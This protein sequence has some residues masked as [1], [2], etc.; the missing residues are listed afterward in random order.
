MRRV[1]VPGTLRDE[2][3]LKGVASRT[4]TPVRSG[5]RAPRCT[6]P[7]AAT[8]GHL[9][10]RSGSWPSSRPGCVGPGRPY[11]ELRLDAISRSAAI[12]CSGPGTNQDQDQDEDQ[13]RRGFDRPGRPESSAD[14]RT[15][16]HR[17]EGRR[18]G[19]IRSS[20]RVRLKVMACCTSLRVPRQVGHLF[21]EQC[22]ER[23]GYNEENYLVRGCQPWSQSESLHAH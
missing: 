8:L 17:R 1:G 9:T 4:I 7:Q 2:S 12:N 14:C 21:G 3:S 16:R 23:H 15:P 13:D 10:A 11:G 19:W 6:H 22:G 18:A 5:R 20:R